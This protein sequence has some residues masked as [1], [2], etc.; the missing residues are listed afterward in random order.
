MNIDK[1]NNQINIYNFPWKI[2]SFKSAMLIG[3]GTAFHSCLLQNIMEQS[4]NL[5]VS[6]D[7]ASEF[8]YRKVDLKVSIYLSHNQVKQ[9]IPCS[10]RFMQ[11]K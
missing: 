6:V 1:F 9:L 2:R 7:I 8:R 11:K 3:C 10:L 5:D 4:T